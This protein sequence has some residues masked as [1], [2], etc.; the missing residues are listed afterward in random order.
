MAIIGNI[1][2]FQTN[3]YI[4]IYHSIPNILPIQPS[5]PRNW[6]TS[7]APTSAA[8]AW[9]PRARLLDGRGEI[10]RWGKM[11]AL[12]QGDEQAT[13]YTW[14]IHGLPSGELTFCH[15][16]I[17][18]SWWENPLFLWPFSIAML[19]H[20]RVYMVYTCFIHGLYHVLTNMTC[21]NDLK[22]WFLIPRLN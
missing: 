8:S 18:H 7:A 9:R 6:A 21:P 1:P 15:G 10:D 12:D 5:T 19:V 2:Y 13:G 4:N 16:K 11:K 17:H 3:P 14:F 22:C 20:Q